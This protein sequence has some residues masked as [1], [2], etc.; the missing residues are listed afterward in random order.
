MLPVYV[1]RAALASNFV[2]QLKNLT[3]PIRR[4]R[5]L[6]PR[7]GILQDTVGHWTSKRVLNQNAIRHQLGHMSGMRSR[8][9]TRAGFELDR[10]EALRSYQSGSL[11]GPRDGD[12]MKQAAAGGV[13]GRLRHRPEARLASLWRFGG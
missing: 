8:P 4:K 7:I 13:G 12:G 9:G 5:N 10:D 1:W 11:G 2:R 6:A 3:F